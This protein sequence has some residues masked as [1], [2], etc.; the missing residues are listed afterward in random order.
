MSF[1]RSKPS[2]GDSKLSD[3][4]SKLSDAHTKPFVDTMLAC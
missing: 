4:R 3:V 1:F 2:N